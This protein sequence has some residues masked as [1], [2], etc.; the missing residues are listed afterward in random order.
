MSTIQEQLQKTIEANHQ[1]EKVS[2]YVANLEDRITEEH[3]KLKELSRNVDREQAEYEQL[4]KLSLKSL[5]HQVLG[6]KE[7]EVE[8]ER[9]EY[10]QAFLRFNEAKK[11]L[12]LLEFERE[13]LVKKLDQKHQLEVEL[14]R[15]IELREKEILQL[16][17]ATA[18]QLRAIDKDID[19]LVRVRVEVNEAIAAGEVAL[20]SLSQMIGYL[21]QARNW[22]HWDL[23]SRGP[24]PSFMKKSSI[25]KAR[26]ISFNVQMELKRFADELRDVY[27]REFSFPFQLESFSGFLDM[28]FDNLI[29]DWIIQNKIKNSLANCVA[30]RDTVLRLH[31]S[32]KAELP[33]IEKDK[34][35]LEQ[36]R[37]NLIINA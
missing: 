27:H 12:E 1:L 29:S 31:G 15:L 28:F 9:Q 10:L 3:E 36:K 24:M 34:A 22:G 23:S 6:N 7:Q 21:N 5:F 25:D 26:A 13:T 33:A 30:V 4:E 32:L 19:Q 11:A 2:N 17:E 35:S 20:N 8:K 18:H 16:N 37:K 14:D